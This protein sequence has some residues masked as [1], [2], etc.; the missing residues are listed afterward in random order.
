MKREL[1]LRRPRDFARV[2]AEGQTYRHPLF[3]MNVAPNGLPHNRYGFVTAKHIGRAVTRNRARRLMRE[4]VRWFHTEIQQG[5]DIVLV[6][7]PVIA[8]EPYSGVL[9]GVRT[10]LERATLVSGGTEDS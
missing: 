10:T 6:A 8:S 9:N 4:A 2:R 7:R 3:F 5:Y 1:R